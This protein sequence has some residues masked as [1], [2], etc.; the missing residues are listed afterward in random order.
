MEV[1]TVVKAKISGENNAT[2]TKLVPVFLPEDLLAWLMGPLGLE[3]PRAA[4]DQYWRHARE[5]ACPWQD[6][7][8]D[9]QHIPLG[10]Y[11]D[12]AKYSPDGKKI[13]GFYLNIVIWCPRVS[14]MSR[15]L[16]FSLDDT[17]CLGLQSLN[18]LFAAVVKSLIRCYDGILVQ[19][20]HHAFCVTELRG[21]W[22]WHALSL[23]LTRTWR[24]HQICWRCD[25]SKEPGV[26]NN[27]LDFRDEP[28][29]AATEL[30]QV[31]FLSRC[32]SAQNP[33]S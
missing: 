32:V 12:A 11:G 14:R 22:E 7:S 26:A 15:W 1:E 25:C 20:Q 17:T 5:N 16:L 21:D 29:W 9:H 18:P 10:L 4:I 2:V 31:E 19:G 8:T 27:M 23:G 6:V 30:T 24:T 13:I 3:V 33:S 28:L